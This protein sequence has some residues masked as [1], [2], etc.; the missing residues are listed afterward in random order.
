M[1]NTKFGTNK[2][3]NHAKKTKNNEWMTNPQLADV[4]MSS[5]VKNQPAN[6]T[7]ICPADSDESEIVKWAKAHNL[8]LDYWPNNFLDLPNHV[9]DPDHN[10][11]CVVTNPPFS[12]F[13]KFL[14]DEGVR[15]VLNHP[16]VSYGFVLPTT[17]IATPSY[18]PYNKTSNFYAIRGN[19]AKFNRPPD[20]KTGKIPDGQ[21]NTTVFMTNVNLDNA[22]PE[23]WLNWHHPP[24]SKR[25]V[26]DIMLPDGKRE[27]S[28]MWLQNHHYMKSQGWEIDHYDYYPPKEL[29][30]FKNLV[31][32]RVVDLDK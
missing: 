12:E 22:W 5:M 24:E 9:K 30:K 31:W 3:L 18:E 11:Y 15:K 23:P 8:K 21:L 14:Q 20:E 4:M 7:Y 13:S 25:P 1:N 2:K 19:L 32:R 27:T 17:N 29:H 28:V 16:N 26:H 10:H 6:T